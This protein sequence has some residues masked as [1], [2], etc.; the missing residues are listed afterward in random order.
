MF[1]RV[2]RSWARWHKNPNSQLHTCC[3]YKM[4]FNRTYAIIGGK[5]QDDSQFGC[6]EATDEEEASCDMPECP[7]TDW[8]DWTKCIGE[9][10][11]AGQVGSKTRTR[12]CIPAVSMRKRIDFRPIIVL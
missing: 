5:L 4:L 12:T 8:G 1:R 3:E 10:C 6:A 2:L 7:Y 9:F 11:G